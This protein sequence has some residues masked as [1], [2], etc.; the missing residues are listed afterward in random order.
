MN[1]PETIPFLTDPAGQEHQ[2]SGALI[3]IGRAIECD[4]VIT[5]K[6]IS[7]EHAQ[8]RREGWRV[9]LSVVT[10]ERPQEK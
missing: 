3:T 9:I 5:G 10:P 7:R 2:L 8:V 4:I 1:T 6:R